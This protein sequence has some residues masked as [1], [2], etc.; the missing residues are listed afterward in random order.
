[1]ASQADA[2]RELGRHGHRVTQTTVSRDL[3]A[4]GARKVAGPDGREGY[5]V[6][7]RLGSNGDGIGAQRLA[8]MLGEFVTTIDHSANLAVLHTPPGS[9]GP[10]AS[11]VD[12]VRPQG[13]LGTIAGDDTVL[14]ITRSAKGGAAIARRF[15]NL[16]EGA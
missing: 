1:M 11:A 2:V 8:R 6:D 5:V 12:A 14:V 3:A 13:V 16:M 7:G 9:A 4:L 10:V 15:R